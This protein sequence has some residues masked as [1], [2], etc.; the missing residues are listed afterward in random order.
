MKIN[1]CFGVTFRHHFQRGII[2]QARNQRKE[3]RNKL[4]SSEKQCM[5]ILR[6]ICNTQID[7]SLWTKSIDFS[8]KMYGAHANNYALEERLMVELLCALWSSCQSSL[9]QIQRYGFDSRY[10]QIIWELVGLKRGS[11]SLV[12]TTE[13]LLPRKSSSSGLESRKY[14]RKDPS[15]WPRDTLYP[16][17]LALTSSASGDRLIGIVRSRTKNTSY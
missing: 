9:L 11:L 8:V 17:K 1:R 13:E 7:W 12:S 15:R 14:G 16:Q 2:D 6:S 10:Y 3:G 5:F 4:T